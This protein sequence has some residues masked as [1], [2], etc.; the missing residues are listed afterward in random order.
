[1]KFENGSKKAWGLVM[2]FGVLKK[3]MPG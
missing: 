2:Q 3:G 1:M